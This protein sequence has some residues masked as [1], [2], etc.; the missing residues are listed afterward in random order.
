MKLSLVIISAFAVG[1]V[2]GYY[3]SLAYDRG[4]NSKGEVLS[5][6]VIEVIDSPTPTPSPT[7]SPSPTNTPIPLSTSSPTPQ[8]ASQT[9]TPIPLP[10]VSPQ[11][12]HGFIERF[13]TQ[14]SVDPN[15]LRHIAVCESGFNPLSVRLSYA[16]LFQFGPTT[17]QKFRL[18]IGEDINP[19]LRLN[20][21]EAVQ[22]AAYALSQNQAHIWPN[23]TP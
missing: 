15:V 9:P 17:W 10:T 3:G 20:A 6:Q 5:Q 4:V 2:F 23:C 12:V 21:E 16:G 11:E 7:S 1:S 14:Y 13:A 18:Q 8:A 22:T 19:D